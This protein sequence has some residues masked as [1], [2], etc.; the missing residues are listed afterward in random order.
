MQCCNFVPYVCV[1][2]VY[3]VFFITSANEGYVFVV[4][5]LSVCLLATLRK[6]FRTH[7]HAILREGWQWASE[8]MI[9]FWW[10]SDRRLDTIQ[11]LFSGFVTIERYG[12]IS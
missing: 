10:R 7:L 4:V 9:K 11:G 8:Q 2:C 5:C 3:C 6:N 1:R 12:L